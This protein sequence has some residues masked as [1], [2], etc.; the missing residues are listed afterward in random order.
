MWSCE[1]LKLRMASDL[2]KQLHITGNSTLRAGGAGQPVSLPQSKIRRWKSSMAKVGAGPCHSPS[3]AVAPA[4]EQNKRR[5]GRMRAGLVSNKKHS[6]AESRGCEHGRNLYRS[7]RV[8][9]VQGCS[10][11]SKNPRTHVQAG[12][13]SARILQC[14][15][16]GVAVAQAKAERPAGDARRREVGPE[17][18]REA[19]GEQSTTTAGS[20]LSTPS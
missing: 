15:G 17:H 8:G 19:T 18:S 10:A 14:R 2:Q 6:G 3:R 16:T 11:V 7:D 9:E 13:G 1:P 4:R 20:R 5:H 12:S